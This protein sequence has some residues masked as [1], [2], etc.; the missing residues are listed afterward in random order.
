VIRRPCLDC[1]QPFSP[2]FSQVSR[3][4]GCERVR[5]AQRN[6]KPE[7]VAL[8]QGSWPAESRA[9]RT[10]EPWCHSLDV[11]LDGCTVTGVASLTVDHP[12]RKALCRSH[13]QRLEWKRRK[14]DTFVAVR[15]RPE[16]VT[17]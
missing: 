5:Q 8:Y 15:E 10:A 6:A 1:G 9:I 12:T 11:G 16:P 13:H 3:C 7:R 2:R 14:A 17:L 4:L